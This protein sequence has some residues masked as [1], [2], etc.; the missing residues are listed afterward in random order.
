MSTIPG[1][2]AIT[3]GGSP[4][5]SPGRGAGGVFAN[6]I[7]GATPKYARNTGDAR[8]DLFR[9]SLARIF[10]RVDQEEWTLFESSF[11][12]S[13]TRTQLLP[14]VAGDPRGTQGYVDFIVQDMNL[15]FN[16]KVDVKETLGDNYVLYTFGQGAP[17]ATFQGVLIN[18]VQD[19]Q[20]TNFLRLYLQLFRAT[21]LARRQKAASIK[22]DSFIFTGVMVNLRMNYR[23]AMEVAVPFSFS[24]IIKKI[25]IINYTIGWR[26]TS[27]GTPFATD[28]NAV[29]ADARIGPER[30]ATAV[31]FVV[32]PDLAPAPTA[33]AASLQPP[34]PAPVADERINAIQ[35]DLIANDNARAAL[36]AREQ[37]I[38]QNHS[39]L[40]DPLENQL[41]GVVQESEQLSE[42]R[43]ALQAALAEA[44]AAPPGAVVATS[45]PVPEGNVPSPEP[46]PSTA[47]TALPE[48][49]PHANLPFTPPV[50]P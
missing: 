16:E 5:Y 33:P 39:V 18:T 11:A 15:D 37:Q 12:D 46:A 32:P 29:P 9:D 41:R 4:L 40:D 6:W 22:I 24:F 34:P 42:R 17:T 30:P 2:D 3:G 25:A 23:A 1:S 27:V 49:A 8:P 50:T 21:E 19:D 13:H 38:R 26:P 35:R 43:T 31:T 47:P 20:A 28:L 10:V 7:Q 36:Q 45:T 48:G 14:R 44:Q